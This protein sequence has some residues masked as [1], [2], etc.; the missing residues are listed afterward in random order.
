MSKQKDFLL[1]VKKYLVNN[2]IDLKDPII[3]DFLERYNILGSTIE[4]MK[5]DLNEQGVSYDYTNKASETNTIKNPL[6]SEL[7]NYIREANSTLKD[8]ISYVNNKHDDVK[9]DKTINLN[10]ETISKNKNS[11]IDKFEKFIS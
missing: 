2:G 4:K 6:L 5:N 8:I 9:K 11:E 3:L 7:K 10:N 1:N